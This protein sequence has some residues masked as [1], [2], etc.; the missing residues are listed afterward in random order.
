MPFLSRHLQQ[1]ESKLNFY[2]N[3]ALPP[4]QADDVLALGERL[5]ARLLADVLMSRGIH[6]LPVDAAN[7][8]LTG[9][10]FGQAK[11]FEKNT[12]DQIANWYTDLEDR[13]V[14]VVTGFIGSD[15][16]GRTTTLGRGGSD[17]SAA[18][19]AAG[20]CARR[21]ERWT[22]VDGIYDRDPNL[23]PDAIR[24]DEL[25]LEEILDLNHEGLLGM[26]RKA[27]DPL[28][29]RQIPIKVHGIDD[30]DGPGT[31]I[32]SKYRTARIL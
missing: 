1:L 3:S 12:L 4:N 31:L 21:L 24:Y 13:V 10:Q 25:V 5:S 15:K 29:Q 19:F 30:P 22:D 7:L 16:K 9:D 8:I 18:L 23:Y 32:L 14:P 28:V 6:A 2:G 17:Y 20:V 26:H 27:L 11:V